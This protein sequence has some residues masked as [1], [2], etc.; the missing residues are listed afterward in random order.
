MLDEMHIALVM[1]MRGEAYGLLYNG[2]NDSLR[3]GAYT[4]FTLIQHKRLG[5]G[6]RRVIPSCVVWQIRDTFPDASG[7]YTGFIP[8]RLI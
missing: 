1:T 5:A 6:N 4:V 8:S 2:D 7:Q 3:H